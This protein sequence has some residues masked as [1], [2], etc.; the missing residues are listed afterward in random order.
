M[1]QREQ[2]PISHRKHVPHDFDNHGITNNPSERSSVLR[3]PLQ[4]IGATIVL[5]GHPIGNSEFFELR[6]TTV[7][8]F[9][10]EKPATKS[11][12]LTIEPLITVFQTPVGG[13]RIYGGGTSKDALRRAKRKGVK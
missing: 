8:H 9:K 11:I 12:P 10:T 6:P 13:G 2:L 3:E 4:E 5:N 7:K 1:N